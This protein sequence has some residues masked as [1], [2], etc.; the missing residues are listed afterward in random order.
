MLFEQKVE[1]NKSRALR[2]D[3]KL[4]KCCR[5][6]YVKEKDGKG[7]EPGREKKNASCKC[8]IAIKCPTKR[9][10]SIGSHTGFTV[11]CYSRYIM[12]VRGGHTFQI[13][14]AFNSGE[15][16]YTVVKVAVREARRISEILCVLVII[17]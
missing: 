15:T 12:Y 2:R 13:A 17:I 4:A 16:S 8:A 5:T 9:T 14:A 7:W 11:S 3:K 10:S 1:R 6:L